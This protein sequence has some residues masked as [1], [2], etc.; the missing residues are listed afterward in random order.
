MAV[1]KANDT[2]S[3]TANFGIKQVDEIF[4]VKR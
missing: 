3:F 4:T 2:P 1:R